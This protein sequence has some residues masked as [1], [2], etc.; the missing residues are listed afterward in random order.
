[1]RPSGAFSQ[2]ERR[3]QNWALRGRDPSEQGKL[4]V[5]TLLKDK[6]VDGPFQIEAR[7]QQ[8]TEVSQQISLWNQMGSRVNRGHLAVVPIENSIR[9]VSRLYPRATSGQLPELKRVIAAYL[10]HIE[11]VRH[12][13]HAAREALAHYNR[14]LERP[15]AGDRSALGLELDA[16]RT[17]LEW[18]DDGRSQNKK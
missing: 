15:K 2:P 16:H 14:A 10:G 9:Y 5:Y 8:N 13:G 1:L 11:V 6:L 12:T 4:I 3:Q 17:L 18:L 7:T